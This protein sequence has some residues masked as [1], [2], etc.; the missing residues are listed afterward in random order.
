MVFP[1]VETDRLVA[2]FEK[3]GVVVPT[4]G[5]KTDAKMRPSEATPKAIVFH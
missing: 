3:S 2:I 5:L 4:F 1:I